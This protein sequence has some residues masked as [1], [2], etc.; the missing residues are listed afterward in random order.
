[1]ARIPVEPQHMKGV[2][3]RV[4]EAN[5]PPGFRAKRRELPKTVPTD[6]V[7]I[8]KAGTFKPAEIKLYP[9]TPSAESHVSSYQQ[10][11]NVTV[12]ELGYHLLANTDNI[13]EILDPIKIK[14]TSATAQ[15]EEKILAGVK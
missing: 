11:D 4:Q 5:T 12:E 7:K 15:K 14:N 13:E 1:M 10:P 9:E 6:T 8:S 2:F 3:Q